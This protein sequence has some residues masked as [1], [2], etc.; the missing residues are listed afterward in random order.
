MFSQLLMLT[1]SLSLCCFRPLLC[2]QPG[3]LVS[4]VVVLIRAAVNHLCTVYPAVILTYV[5]LGGCH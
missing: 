4:G 3:L 1:L 2:C 5:D